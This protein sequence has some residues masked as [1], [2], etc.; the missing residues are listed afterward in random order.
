MALQVSFDY[1][2]A[3][4]TYAD[5][6]L[7][8]YLI[9]DPSG[10][11]VVIQPTPYTILNTSV[12]SRWQGTFQ[13]STSV[14]S[15]RLVIHVASTSASAYTVKFDNF[16]VGPQ[17][18]SYGPFIS[19][20]TAY[21]PTIS[22]L[23]TGS[24][25]ANGAYYRRVGDSLEVSGYFVKDGSG[26]S[27]TGTAVTISIPSGLTIDTAKIPGTAG[28]LD[29]NIGAASILSGATRWEGT[30]QYYST[31]AVGLLMYDGTTGDH[32]VVGADVVANARVGYSFK[33]PITGWSSGQL[34]SSDA[35]TRVLS[36][37]TYRTSS[38]Q[39][40]SNATPTKIQLNATSF[41]KN[42]TAD[43][44]TNY[45][46]TVAVPGV[47]DIKGSVSYAANA[48]GVRYCMIYKNG[49]QIAAS[50]MPTAGAG[51]A[52][53]VQ[54]ATELDLIAG[55]YIELYGSQSSGG[56]L[57]VNTGVD[58]TYLSVSKKA[59]PS[60]I[61]ASE[62]ISF[63]VHTSTTAASTSA[64]F[65][66][67][68]TYSNSHGAYSTST[69]IFT[70]PA[71]GRYFFGASV[72]VGASSSTIFMYKNGTS[73]AQGIPVTGTPN[74]SAVTAILVLNTGDTVEVRPDASVTATGGANLNRFYGFKIG[75]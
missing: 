63:S 60:Q 65:I 33:V 66:Y 57:N 61:A 21:T 26:G 43:I 20:A 27:G 9:E 75:R 13:T 8:V 3:S 68:S 35:E 23:G 41:D 49:S 5:G 74:G 39:S 19:D 34:L 30:T 4:G 11:P 15:Y 18:K 6:D 14:T 52:S 29:Q 64:P 31:T 55:D 25:A 7:T 10:T 54:C 24:T 37:K 51:D 70:A 17:T 62:E 12:N 58:V 42:G 28:Q 71:P 2:I 1:A 47:Y 44:T 73:I 69:G 53:I 40:L 22:N 45:R 38:T 46:I 32:A 50:T 16:Y 59:G 36:T 48:T 67:T 72:Y 56:S